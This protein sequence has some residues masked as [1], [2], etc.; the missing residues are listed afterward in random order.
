[1][2]I[3]KL[4]I[5]LMMFAS[6]S[7]GAVIFQDNF[8][9]YTDAPTNHGWQ[10][11]GSQVSTPS[12][13]GRNG[14][15]GL[16]V[17]FI[18]ENTAPYS[19]QKSLATLNL[20]EVYV[21]FY[22]KVGPNPT[23][24]CKFVKFFGKQNSPSGY[25]NTTF[26]LN[27]DSNTLYDIQYGAGAIENDNGNVIRYS[28]DHPTWLTSFDT[29]VNMLTALGAFDPKDGQWHSMEVFMRYNSNGQ[30]DGE[31]K[32]WTDG[33]LRVHATNVVN[34]N[35]LNSPHFLEF[36]LGD[37]TSNKNVTTWSLYYDDVVVS[38]T[39]IGEGEPTE[40][41]L[42]ICGPAHGETF[43]EL[44]SDNPN[45]CSQGTV[46]TFA[47]DGPWNWPCLGISGGADVNCTAFYEEPTADENGLCGAADGGNF[48]DLA[49]TDPSLCLKGTVS[50]WTV[51]PDGW[52]WMCDGTGTGTDDPCN[53]DKILFEGGGIIRASGS[54]NLY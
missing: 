23:G 16:K 31:Y 3:F 15:R 45:L 32:V 36:R 22:Y 52:L 11:I 46:G 13:E 21:R 12:T 33:T 24:G 40:T 20:Q 39:R 35:D 25:A 30:R 38:T 27:Y 41:T 17:T 47:G 9:G 10:Y 54:F 5:A 51:D 34:R 43:S 26:M 42:G 29:N 18:G 8:D 7:H 14:T 19:I 1:M 28:G 49:E 4:F 2:K 37:Y 44:S 53:A 50:S 6:L 48:S